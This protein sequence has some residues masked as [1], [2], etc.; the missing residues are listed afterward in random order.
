MRKRMTISTN[1]KIG[2]IIVIIIIIII[3]IIIYPD[4]RNKAKVAYCFS[5]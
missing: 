1:T 3:I 5:L 2:K 4:R